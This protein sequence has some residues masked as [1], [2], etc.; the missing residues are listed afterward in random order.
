MSD[1]IV[2]MSITRIEAAHLGGLVRQFQELLDGESDTALV[3]AAVARLTPPAYRDDEQAASEF[4][5]LTAGDL[6]ARRDADAQVVLHSIADAA[7]LPSEDPDDPA[8]VEE[9]AVSL[10]RE[11][12]HAWLR[13][14]AAV[15]LVLATRLGI[16]DADDRDEDDQRFGIYDWLGY[17][18]DGLVQA[19]DE[20]GFT[21]S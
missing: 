4:R 9:V 11:S 6:L 3:D 15:R 5:G 12:L 13:T 10:D 16:L 7:T 19:A 21:R 20:S 8:L 18:L 1:G 17:R 14:L 2:M